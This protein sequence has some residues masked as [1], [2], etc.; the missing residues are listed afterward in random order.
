VRVAAAP[1]GSHLPV[2]YPI[3]VLREST[4]PEDAKA[5]VATVRSAAGQAILARYGFKPAPAAR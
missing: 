4:H 2:I 5:F 1:A 3:A